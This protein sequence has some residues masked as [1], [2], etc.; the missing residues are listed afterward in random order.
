MLQSQPIVCLLNVGVFSHTKHW[1]ISYNPVY[2]SHGAGSASCGLRGHRLSQSD[3]LLFIISQNNIW[4]WEFNHAATFFPVER[5]QFL[6]LT[7]GTSWNKPLCLL[8]LCS[9]LSGQPHVL[10]AGPQSGPA[11][12]MV[13]LDFLI[14]HLKWREKAALA[15]GV[16]AA[17]LSKPILPL[18]QAEKSKGERRLTVLPCLILGGRTCLLDTED[19]V[20]ILNFLYEVKALIPYCQ[21]VLLL[22]QFSL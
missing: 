4:R 13:H 5:S 22:S 6:P 14:L 7:S 9:V 21:E 1:N 16:V 15:G 12:S 19:G 20:I 11:H 3:H 8:T 10:D 2:P 17:A 18:T